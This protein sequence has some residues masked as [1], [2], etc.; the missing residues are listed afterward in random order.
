[1]PADRPQMPG[2][3]L[4]YYYPTAFWFRTAAT[5]MD[6]VEA[7]ER[8]SQFRIRKAEHRLARFPSRSRS[9]TSSW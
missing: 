2:G 1:M 3:V 8:Y 7:F 5:I 4:L 9:T 6:H